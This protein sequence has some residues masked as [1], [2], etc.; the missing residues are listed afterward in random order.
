V[1]KIISLKNLKKIIKKLKKLKKKIVFTNG[2]FDILH[3]G[4]IKL[5]KKAKTYGDILI[6]GLNSDDSVR[7][8]KKSG[9]PIMPQRER[10]EI[11][12]SIEYVDYLTIFNEDT[13]IELIK[14]I[15]PDVLIKGADYK[16]KEIVGSDIVPK[17]IR[18]KLIKGKSTTS[19]LEKIK[20]L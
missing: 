4:H 3:I 11:V 8:L 1:K 5:F 16:L 15:K 10:S 7:R 2:C 6:V 9:R 13:P 19:L 17:T 12:S 14:E 18:F 20:N